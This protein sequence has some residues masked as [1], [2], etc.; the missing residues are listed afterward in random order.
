MK[1]NIVKE[2]N[3]HNHREPSII[4]GIIAQ[5]WYI[6]E[7]PANMGFCIACFCVILGAL[8]F[9]VQLRFSISAKL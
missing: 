9:H 8:G 1:R 5:H 4:I 6:S 7:N 3:T 2:K